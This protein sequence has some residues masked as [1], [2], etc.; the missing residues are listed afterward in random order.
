MGIRSSKY[1]IRLVLFN[2]LLS[3]IPVILM[4]AF[5]YFKLYGIIQDKVT[6]G[7]MQVLFQD[8]MRVEQVLKVADNTAIQ[9]INSSLVTNALNLEFSLYEYK[10]IEQLTQ[11]LHRLQ[12]FE[13]G[14]SDIE[15]LS[16]DKNW[17]INNAGVFRLDEY[18]QKDEIQKYAGVSKTSFWTS[19]VKGLN[20]GSLFNRV[21]LIKKLPTNNL[22]PLGLIIINIP[23]LEINKLISDG[24]NAG[25]VLILDDEYHVITSKNADAIG[26]DFSASLY[27]NELQKNKAPN[28]NFS[29]KVQNDKMAVNYRISDYNGWI[30]LSIISIKDII[31][32]S[33]TI[34]LITLFTSIVIVILVSIVSYQG[35]KRIYNPIKKLYDSVVENSVQN[36]NN[37][38]RDELQF[39]GERINTL[40]STNSQMTAQLL[41]QIQQLKDFFVLRLF[42]NEVDPDDIKDRL[43]YFGYTYDFKWLSIIAVQIDTLEDTTYKEQD[44]DIAML[45]INNLVKELI[46]P[47][48][49]LNPILI[50][51]YQVTLVG[52]NHSTVDAFK[53]H[54]YFMSEMVEKSVKEHLGLSV[55]IGISYPY[56]DFGKTSKAYKEAVEALKY[57]VNMDKA[58]I[59]FIG[60]IKI[61]HSESYVFPKQLEN[62]LI[63]AIKITNID[64]VNNLF[65]QFLKEVVQTDLGYSGFQTSMVR[66]LTDL[67][68]LAQDADISG[69]LLYKDNKSLYEQFFELKTVQYIEAW[70][71]SYVIYP[72]IELLKEQR[73]EQYKKI[74]NEIIRMIQEKFDTDLTL[75][76][77]ASRINYHPSYVRRVFKKETGVNFSDYMSMYRLNIAKKWLTETDVKITEIAERLKYNNPQNFIRYFRKIEG[78]TPGQY[79]DLNKQ[80]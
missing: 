70:F 42:K 31:I 39:I 74:S 21:C 37:N 52:D 27:V 28:G 51:Q 40:L 66:F 67:V 25:E 1:L 2:L 72:I 33:R 43:K 71:K 35:S 4:G 23:N 60:D 58:S 22:N 47:D 7:D 62:D 49:R 14:I 54:I 46:A 45:A 6:Q 16:F 44:R 30:Y 29:V 8:Q 3:T 68:R 18:E 15:L 65:N 10:T 79:R 41:G 59:L 56:D 12:T 20:K 80:E 36:G 13:L 64:K 57:R 78:I 26:K 77:C 9:F 76:I 50:N 53:S 48:R 34:G 38:R 11:G 73:G 75:E 55:S 69:E 63:D 19:E 32:D 17:I 61:G 24:V 5:S